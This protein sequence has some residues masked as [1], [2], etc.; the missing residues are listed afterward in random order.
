MEGPLPSTILRNAVVVTTGVWV[1]VKLQPVIAL[2]ST[3]SAFTIAVG[4]VTAIGATLISAAQIDIKRILSYLSSAYMGLM[5]IAI[6]VHL[7]QTALLL[8]LPYAL[9]MATLVMAC[10]SVIQN[11]IT[12]D[13][14]QMGGLWSRR[15]ITALAMITG[16][17]GLVGLPPLG[18]FWATLSLVSGLWDS[19][20]GL[21]VAIV[22]IVN[23]I[24]AFSLARMIG[25]IF[26]GQT[27]QMTVRAP[28][29]LWLLVMPMTLAGGFT[30]HLPLILIQLGL[31]PVWANVSKDMALLL[32]W[33]SLLGAALGTLLYVNRVIENPAK[34]IQKPVQNLLAYDFYTPKLYRNTFVLGVDWLSKVTDWLDR[35]VV[36]GL[37][38]AVGLASIFGGE[39]L[40]YS[41][42]GRLQFYAL[43]IACGVALLGVLMSWQYLTVLF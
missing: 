22:L 37:V 18:G 30:L 42:S 16:A 33:S 27:Q 14:A 2:S 5:F 41:N 29:P 3:A 20:R 34:L 32:T 39:T 6:G 35:Y 12:Q 10:G 40:K 11:V 4:A 8:A 9:A 31:L 7:P 13:V 38:N 24:A 26:A 25:L 17:A 43:T 28:E 36:D 23:W 1:L 19:H 15:P 21:L